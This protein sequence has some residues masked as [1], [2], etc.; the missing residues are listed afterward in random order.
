[1]TNVKWGRVLEH[2]ARIVESYDT[3][4]TLRQL[5][6]RLIAATLIPNTAS[7]Y[8]TLSAR[9]AAARR[10]GAFPD[11]IDNTRW[12]RE[13]RTFTSPAAAL[14]YTAAIYRRDRTD[15]QD[16]AVYLGVE[17]AGHIHQLDQWFGDY[18]VPILPLGGYASQTFVDDV[19]AHVARQ[20]RPAAL[21]YAGD[22]DA[23]GIPIGRDFI[24]RADCWDIE[25]VRVALNPREIDGYGLTRQRGKHTDANVA[26]FVREFGDVALF[27]P[28]D[29]YITDGGRRYLSP[30]QVEMDAL[31]PNDLREL[32]TG[33]INEFWDM[34]TY[35]AVLERETDERAALADL[36]DNW[37]G[38]ME[39]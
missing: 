30:V 33:A 10:D 36:A 21:I 28:A 20:R 38:R 24:A 29:P 8:K 3:L 37:P 17:K 2:A 1:M 34:S 12:I 5:F 27:D 19:R 18:G 22:F 13:Y 7:A 16:V 39:P 6:Y 32:F 25:P 9:T 31:D 23:S 35:E 11:L 26:A 14:R 4:V 15:G